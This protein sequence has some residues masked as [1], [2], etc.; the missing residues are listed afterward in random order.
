MMVTV[1]WTNIYH[2][3]IGKSLLISFI[4]AY[5]PT[6]QEQQELNRV[7]VKP[8]CAVIRLN[9]TIFFA[10]PLGMF[11]IFMEFTLRITFDTLANGGIMVHERNSL[12]LVYQSVSVVREQKC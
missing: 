2:C 1:T 12:R 11:N 7:G 10:G 5:I 6:I 4:H 3:I 8:K 9:S